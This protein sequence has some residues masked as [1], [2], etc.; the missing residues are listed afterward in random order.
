[1]AA[2]VAAPGRPRPGRRV[3]CS[4]RLR[5]RTVRG[6]PGPPR[7]GPSATEPGS[8]YPPPH[9]ALTAAAPMRIEFE[10]SAGTR[11]APPA[12]CWAND[13]GS[14]VRRA[15][16]RGGERAGG[17]RP[18]AGADRPRVRPRPRL[19]L[20]AR[21]APAA[22][23][24]TAPSGPV[25]SRGRTS[26]CRTGRCPVGSAAVLASKKY[27]SRSSSRSASPS[28]RETTS[29]SGRRATRCGSSMLAWPGPSTPRSTPPD[30][31]RSS[32]PDSPAS[33]PT[34]TTERPR[35]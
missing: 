11:G 20:A 27:W 23:P 10:P 26:T 16:R 19:G 18:A 15:P 12:T 3:P 5:R 4:S 21:L 31:S 32:T 1:M 22:H 2:L 35:R 13:T 29:P 24:A 34:A 14:G 17:R 6:G 7:A 30:G 28:P 8:S 33:P 25:T 9:G